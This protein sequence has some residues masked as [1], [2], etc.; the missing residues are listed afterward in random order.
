M[1]YAEVRSRNKFFEVARTARKGKVVVEM[2]GPP[3]KRAHLT[4]EINMLPPPPSPPVIEESTPIQLES[5]TRGDSAAIL[6]SVE[7]STKNASVKSQWPHNIQ[8]LVLALTQMTSLIK[9]PHLSVLI[10][11]NALRP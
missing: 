3:L 5:S 4:E 1:F 2:T 11:K 9:E 8:H 10:A 7:L 6:V